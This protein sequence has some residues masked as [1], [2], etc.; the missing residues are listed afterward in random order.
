MNVVC[1]WFKWCES[2]VSYS[3]NQLLLQQ[4]LECLRLELSVCRLQQI[5]K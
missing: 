3:W 5:R 4:K 2:F 1:E